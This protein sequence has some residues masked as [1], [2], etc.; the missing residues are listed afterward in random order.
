MNKHH[1]RSGFMLLML[2]AFTSI[3][4]GLSVTFYVY[5]KRSM[6]D[7]HMA[8]KIAN[9][10]LALRAAINYVSQVT[11]GA[12]IY[13]NAD[14]NSY[15]TNGVK[16][17]DLNGS[18]PRGLSLGWYRIKQAGVADQLYITAGTGPSNGWGG[19]PEPQPANWTD[20]KWN[21]ELRGWYLVNVRAG[22]YSGSGGSPAI[23]NIQ[24]LTT[25]PAA[26]I[27]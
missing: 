6:E 1:A 17:V 26:G 24:Q 22:S 15:V 25:P 23:S 14:Y 7:S 27:W 16:I 21:D 5:C 13:G 18:S 4:L 9:Q 19:T 11:S 12:A 10:R 8:V 20:G 3:I 2:I